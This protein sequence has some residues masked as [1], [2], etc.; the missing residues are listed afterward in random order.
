M[1]RKKIPSII[2]G[3][4][5]V[6][7]LSPFMEAKE[8][9][10]SLGF[11]VGVSAWPS[12]V[13]HY[14]RM[15]PKLSFKY[16]WRGMNLLQ[17]EIHLE[18]IYN[19]HF[20]H[21]FTSY[22]GLQ[23]EIGHQKARYKSNFAMF[24]WH[25]EARIEYTKHWLSWSVSSIL[26]HAIFQA[27]KSS[28][29]IVPY[30]FLGLGLCYVRGEEEEAADYYIKIHPSVDLTLKTGG[31]VSFYFTRNSPLGLNLRA[32]IMVL[33]ASLFGFYSAYGGSNFV[34]GTDIVAQGV[35]IIWGIEL[36]LRYRF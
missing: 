36:G 22:F 13:F 23:A 11:A 35:D 4:V 15:E 16:S 34:H 8:K 17:Q 24:P 33:G 7:L 14:I 20:Q 18:P 1:S 21:N 25:S 10:Y 19:F 32:F 9:G 2:L 30:G 3:C 12:D 29:S 5:F 31:G 27:R 6:F 26:L 28:E